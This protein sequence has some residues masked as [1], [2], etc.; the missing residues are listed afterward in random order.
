MAI[1]DW[2][3]KKAVIKTLLNFSND[4]LVVE[5]TCKDK[6]MLEQMRG[7]SIESLKTHYKYEW[8][9]RTYR[10]SEGSKYLAFFET[11]AKFLSCN[12]QKHGHALAFM[13][14]TNFL[15][16]L[17]VEDQK[18]LKEACDQNIFLSLT[19]EIEDSI[20]ITLSNNHLSTSLNT[21]D[22]S[23]FFEISVYEP[24]NSLVLLKDGLSKKSID[25]S[26][27]YQRPESS[28]LWLSITS[29]PIY[30]GTNQCQA[31]LSR[32]CISEEWR[33]YI[34]DQHFS[35]I[36]MLAGGGSHLK[37]CI[38]LNSLI[39]RK[40]DLEKTATPVIYSFLDVSYFM[41]I[42]SGRKLQRKIIEENLENHIILKSIVF[43]ILKFSNKNEFKKFRLQEHGKIA[44]FLTG[45]TLGN[46]DEKQ[47]FTSLKN[48]VNIGDRLIIGIE[49][50]SKDINNQYKNELLKKYN[51]G[52]VKKLISVPLE[53]IKSGLKS[54]DTFDDVAESMEMSVRTEADDCLSQVPNSVSVVA[55][56]KTHSYGPINLFKSTRYSEQDLI[57]FANQYHW[58]FIESHE[59]ID[60][61][62]KQL[63]FEYQPSS[64]H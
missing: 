3:T 62:F 19:R 53:A 46:F 18:K 15:S 13:D 30:T 37:D 44:W 48:V 2:N 8:K 14:L 31:A 63:I 40:I 22:S 20:N 54:E 52:S 28:E 50:A 26:L 11:L 27:Y 42:D 51:N 57:T 60:N 16:T 24:E 12:E 21:K 4:D 5:F 34:R 43:D 32:L 36:V 10:L 33:S 9:K 64:S 6:N 56:I 17:P 1:P 55:S 25:Q 7:V 39:E 29:D 38:I 23:P 47:F 61:S 45:G 58:T 41:L 49:L 59:G 35:G